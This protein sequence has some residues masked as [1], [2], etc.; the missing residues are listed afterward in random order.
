MKQEYELSP[1]TIAHK[2]FMKTV[3]DKL[4]TQPNIKVCDDE[5]KL[6]DTIWNQHEQKEQAERFQM[7]AKVVQIDDPIT[8][9]PLVKIR[10]P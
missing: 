3:V 1:R 9:R 8:K 5:P 7:K 10:N 6:V 4:A 2:R